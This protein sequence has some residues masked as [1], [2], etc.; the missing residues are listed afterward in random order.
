MKK[1]GTIML[2]GLIALAIF[3]S[4]MVFSM[5]D[6]AYA[7]STNATQQVSSMTSPAIQLPMHRGGD[8]GGDRDKHPGKGHKVSS[9]EI[10]NILAKWSGFSTETLTSVMET[11]KLNIP[12]LINATVLAKAGNIS[13]DTAAKVVS[14]GKIMEY[15]EKN[16]LLEKF[17]ETR[18]ELAQ[19]MR[20][21]KDGYKYCMKHFHHKRASE[22]MGGI[23][24][25]FTGV[26]AEWANISTETIISI[27]NT[28]NLNPARTINVV[29][30]AKVGG[31][32]LQES[33]SIVINGELGIFLV[34]NNLVEKF[35]EAR[36]EVMQLLTEK[37]LQ[38]RE[39]FEEK[40]AEVLA[41]WS[42]FNKDDIAKL[43][44][45]QNIGYAS[46]VVV[47]GKIAGIS[48]DEAKKIVDEGRLM[49][50][51]AEKELFMKFSQAKM[52]VMRLI[53]QALRP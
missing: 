42:G 30:L 40:V 46:T 3:I 41:K 49:S 35:M 38:I 12:Q 29:V 48:L 25:N 28:Y 1:I 24:S 7:I 13:L 51:L 33:A 45:E 9:R 31:I 27:Q 43:I 47:L 15:V 11:Y 23:W 50:Y 18:R 16:Q 5:P 19:Y 17:M 53:S 37:A 32:D 44:E 14:E 39:T 4:P 2:A 8:K 34:K 21:F 22:A 36:Q 20:G 6:S 26:L 10:V 52:E